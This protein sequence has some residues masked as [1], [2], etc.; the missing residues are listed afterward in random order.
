MARIHGNAHE[1]AYG[2]DEVFINKAG[3]VNNVD[4]FTSEPEELSEAAGLSFEQ[5]TPEH[6]RG[7]KDYEV[8]FVLCQKKKRRSMNI[9]S[10]HCC[11]KTL[12]P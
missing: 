5:N 8:E 1:H 4:C 10:Y 2:Y 3:D 9:A 7:L 6:L 11:K 12:H